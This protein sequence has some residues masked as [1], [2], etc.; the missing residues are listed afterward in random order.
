MAVV[1]LSQ[2]LCNDGL[3]GYLP[4]SSACFQVNN[5]YLPKLKVETEGF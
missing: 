2:H 4:A 3:S 5:T 1:Y